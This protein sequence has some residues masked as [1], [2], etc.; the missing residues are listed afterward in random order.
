M[1]FAGDFAPH[2]GYE[3]PVITLGAAIFGD[4][5]ED[6]ATADI[7][8]LNLEAPLCLHGKPIRKTGPS[9]RAHPDCLHAVADA[10]FNVAGLANN[11]IMDYGVTGFGETLRAVTSHGLK[12]CGAGQYLQQAQQACHVEVKGLRIALIAVA[13]HEFSIASSDH[14]GAAPL[15]SIDNVLQI[16]QAHKEADLVFVSVHGGNE[17]FPLPRPGL[18]KLCQYLTNR[19]ADAV[20]C[21]HTHIP[22]AYEI[23]EGKPIIYSLGNLIF[24]HP[25]PPENWDKGYAAILKY[26]SDTR[27]FIAFNFLPYSQSVSQKGVR[28]MYGDQKANFLLQLDKFYTVLQNNELYLSEWKRFCFSKKNLLLLKQYSPFMFRGMRKVSSILNSEK[29]FL[30]NKTSRNVKLNMIRCE[31]HLEMLRTILTEE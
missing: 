29:I 12:V 15:D 23:H 17:Y 18:R 2:G 26:S 10:G 13:E 25:H 31:S 9:L 24:D 20:I 22:G 21:H 14:P 19:G 28:K 4:L 27:K 6:I 7:A 1:L 16:E 11:H 30:L 3:K 8:F 5:Q